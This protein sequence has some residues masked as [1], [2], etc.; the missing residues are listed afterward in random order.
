[1][2]S[3]TKTVS[4]NNYTYAVTDMTGAIAT[5]VMA[6]NVVTGPTVTFS[7]AAVHEDAVWQIANLLNQ[8]GSGLVPVINGQ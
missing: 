1:M 8:M 2:A 5:L 3:I 6:T 7:G 4:G